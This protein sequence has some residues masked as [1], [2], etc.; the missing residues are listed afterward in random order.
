MRIVERSVPHTSFVY[1]KS[2]KETKLN[3]RAHSSNQISVSY[4]TLTF[5]YIGPVYFR[6]IVFTIDS[7]STFEGNFV[8]ATL[9]DQQTQSQAPTQARTSTQKRYP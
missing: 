9:A 2:Q 3:I 6:P 7:D 4:V 8:L 5:V 1:F